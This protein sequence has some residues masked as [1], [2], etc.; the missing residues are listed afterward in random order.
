M[1]NYE[2]NFNEC[3]T[4]KIL[5]ARYEIFRSAKLVNFYVKLTIYSFGSGKNYTDSDGSR[6]TAHIVL[7][8]FH[9]FIKNNFCGVL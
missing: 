3:T 7:L 9:K 2:L 8:R 1:I 5:E 6:L 4:W